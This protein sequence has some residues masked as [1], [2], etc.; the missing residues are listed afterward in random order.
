MAATMTDIV[1]VV[2]FFPKANHS[3][4]FSA[5][6]S[7]K[8]SDFIS[9]FRS[10]LS[11]MDIGGPGYMLYAPNRRVAGGPGI[12]L[13]PTS[14]VG[15]YE[16]LFD[17]SLHYRSTERQIAVRILNNTSSVVTIDEREPLRKAVVA[18]CNR[19]GVAPTDEYG[20]MVDVASTHE[21]RERIILQGM[22]STVAPPPRSTSLIFDQP[23]RKRRRPAALAALNDQ[24][25]FLDLQKS[26]VE[27]ALDEA[28]V[29]LFKRRFYFNDYFST[30]SDF[31]TLSMHFYQAAYDITNGRYCTPRH[32]LCKLGALFLQATL[33]DYQ[34]HIARTVDLSALLTADLL[35]E[36]KHEKR[37]IQLIKEMW[38]SISPGM[39]NQASAM[40]EYM[41]TTREIKD[42]GSTYYIALEPGA[43]LDKLQQLAIGISRDFITI[44]DNKERVRSGLILMLFYCIFANVYC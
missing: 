21:S 2:V 23:E 9:A 15:D 31:P 20:L 33:G 10:K 13:N 26:M 14:V 36:G 6:R 40:H 44:V 29:F 16:H 38:Q 42:Y 1:R 34:D 5:K 12:Y 8:I 24:D 39:L 22:L 3:N 17:H 30:P 28:T 4:Q 25:I 18:V 43:R 35:H 37:A 27:L 32:I 7:M 11:S 19:L 41:Q